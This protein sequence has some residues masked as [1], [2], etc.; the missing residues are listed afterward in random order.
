M[1]VNFG[2]HG[3]GATFVCASIIFWADLGN[4]ALAFIAQ[5]WLYPYFER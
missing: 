2:G 5:G 4:N 1:V 3:I